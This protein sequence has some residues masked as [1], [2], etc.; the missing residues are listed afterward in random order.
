MAAARTGEID[1]RY[2]Q[3]LALLLLVSISFSLNCINNAT[4]WIFQEQGVLIGV[5]LILTVLTIVISYIVGV[6]SKNVQFTVFAKDEL[7]HLGFSIIFLAAFGAIL[8]FSCNVVEMFY[9]TTI[10]ELAP[11]SPCYDSHFSM[12]DVT[13]C[14]MNSMSSKAKTMSENY[15]D[16]YVGKLMA[17]TWS[18]SMSLPLL[19]SYTVTAKAYR[20]VESAQY[21]TVL[22]MFLFPVV[23]SLSVQEL[24]LTF[25]VVEFVRWLLPIAFVLRIFIPTRQ[26]G[27]LLIALA[28][29]L[30]IVLPFVYVFNFAMYDVLYQGCEQDLVYDDVFGGCGDPNSFWEVASL[31]PQAFFLPNLTIALVVTFMISINKA[32]RV[33]G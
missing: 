16:N 30:H 21:D 33:I 26:M 5:V 8:L 10:E 23:V 19:H 1:M 2:T 15:I 13:L 32:L 29:A 12:G 14:Y 7:Y 24:L 9:S 4:D 22:N 18:F 28:I 20:R 17:S 3:L 11:T 27:N 31:V 6:F 25:V